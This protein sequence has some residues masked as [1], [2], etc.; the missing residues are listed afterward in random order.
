MV[1]PYTRLDQKQ[2]RHR[3]GLAVEDSRYHLAAAPF[4]L[5]LVVGHALPGRQH[6][7]DDDNLLPL[8]IPHD[9]VIPFEYVI[10]ATL[11]LVQAL[12]RLEHIHIVQPRCQLRPVLT[13]I[14]VEAFEALTVFYPVATRHEHDMIRLA[15]RL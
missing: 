13:D 5:L 11:V 12:P 3:N 7:V 2:R 14:L 9:T 10:L 4:Y 8:D 1:S 6:I 15:V